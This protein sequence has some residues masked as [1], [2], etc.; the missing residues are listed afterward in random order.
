MTNDFDWDADFRRNGMS[1]ADQV[2]RVLALEQIK[3][4]H[5]ALE[6]MIERMLTSP[7][8]VG[9]AIVV[10]N[11]VETGSFE[12]GDYRIRSERHYRLDPGVPFGRMYEFPSMD[13]YEMWQERGCPPPV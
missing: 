10:Q 13:A 5:N 8:E 1:A 4:G 3:V 7:L 6:E 2:I 9:I 11:D 12:T